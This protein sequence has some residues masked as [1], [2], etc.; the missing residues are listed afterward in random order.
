MRIEDMNNDKFIEKLQI[1]DYNEFSVEMIM[2]IK[3][4]N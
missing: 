3:R 2:S 4:K 1:G